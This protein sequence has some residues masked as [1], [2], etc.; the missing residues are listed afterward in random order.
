MQFY[1]EPRVARITGKKGQWPD[2][3]EF[4]IEEAPGENGDKQYIFNK[5]NYEFNPEQNRYVSEPNFQQIGPTKGLM[6]I[7]IMSGTA[8]PY[9]KTTRSNIAFK[10]F[11]SGVIDDEALL[12]TLEWPDA[13][14]ILNRKREAQAALPPPESGGPTPAPQPQGAPQ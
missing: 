5:K 2:Y 1:R 12:D 7:K 10:L 3:F 14:Q 9:S 6:D 8:M 11:D 13:E 4:F